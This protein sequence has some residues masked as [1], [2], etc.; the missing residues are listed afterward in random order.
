VLAGVRVIPQSLNELWQMLLD[1]LN[2]PDCGGNP[3]NA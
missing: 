1:V 3:A 2:S